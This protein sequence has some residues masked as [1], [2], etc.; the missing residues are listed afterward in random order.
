MGVNDLTNLRSGQT[1]SV[2]QVIPHPDFEESR[3]VNN[4]AVLVLDSAI[5]LV[6]DDDVNAACLP[7]CDEMFDYQFANG[8]GT[9]CW[10]S[11]FGKNVHG[12]VQNTMSKIDVPIFP[13]EDCSVVLRDEFVRIQPGVTKVSISL[14]FL[15]F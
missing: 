11:G 5:D 1:F 15:L 3:L 9:R 12:V 4:I 7:Q 10:I 8:T 14:S 13:A 2:S 6:S